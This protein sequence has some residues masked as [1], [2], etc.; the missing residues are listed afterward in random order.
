MFTQNKLNENELNEVEEKEK[1]GVE[2]RVCPRCKSV[3]SY[4]ER[5]KVYGRESY[6]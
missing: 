6:A 5:K 1:K 4:I 3:Y 2:I